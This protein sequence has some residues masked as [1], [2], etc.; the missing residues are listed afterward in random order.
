MKGIRN[1]FE[2]ETHT[3][4]KVKSNVPKFDDSRFRFNKM[5]VREFQVSTKSQ[6][7]PGDMSTKRIQ[8]RILETNVDSIVIPLL[9]S[10]KPYETECRIVR[11]KSRSTIVKDVLCLSQGRNRI[12]PSTLK[13]QNC[14]NTQNF[15]YKHRRW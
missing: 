6:S 12:K 8:N 10:S 3:K 15:F 11:W 14:L 9:F 1:Q 13:G 7:I 4:K 2:K 5:T